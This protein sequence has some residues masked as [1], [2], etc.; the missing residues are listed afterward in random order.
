MIKKLLILSLSAALILAVVTPGADVTCNS[1]TD[2]T[3]CGPAGASTWAAGSTA[4]KFKIADC[5][6][7]GSSLTGV[8]DTLCT[9]CPPSAGNVYA[10]PDQT[11]CINTPTA[12]SNV[13]CQ[14]AGAC[15]NCGT[16]PQAFSWTKASDTTNCVV[17]S[18]FAAPQPTTGLTDNFCGSCQ[19][20]NKFAN[21]YG[22]ACVNPTGGNCTRK[23]SWTDDDCKLCNA[24]GANSTNVKAS[25]DKTSC[26]AASSS[27]QIIAVSALF[28]ASLFI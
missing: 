2:S 7:V 20:T 3:T 27:S 12:G 21:S 24:G 26:V 28:L 16:L 5:T 18:C 8:F 4:N 17:K 10:K 13:A 11:G 14:Q 1:N 25:A 23:A 22:T 9:S 15:D 6:A 19:K